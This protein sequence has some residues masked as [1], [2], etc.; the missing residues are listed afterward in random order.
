MNIALWLERTA[1]TSGGKPALLLGDTVVGS[2][3]N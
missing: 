1:A 2:Y 3:R